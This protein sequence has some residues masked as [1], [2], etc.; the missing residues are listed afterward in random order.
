MDDYACTVKHDDSISVCFNIE[1]DKPFDI[2]N[3]MNGINGSAYMNGYNWEAFFNYYLSNYAPDVLEGMQTD[4][5]AG[6][7]AAYYP[8]TPENEARAEKLVKIICNLIENEEEL[9]RIIRDE[10][11]EIEWD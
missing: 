7:Y 1:Q 9:Y 4:P 5:E 2:G 11:D 3:K 10:G 8:L 6:M